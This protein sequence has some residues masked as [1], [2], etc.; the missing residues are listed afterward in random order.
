MPNF[1]LKTPIEDA[2]SGVGK[3]FLSQL[4]RLGIKTVKDL[5]WHLPTRYEDRSEIL[6]IT[7]IQGGEEA[8][9]RGIVQKNTTKRIPYRHLAITEVSIIDEDGSPLTVTFFNQPYIENTLKE[10]KV[11]V[12]KRS[13]EKAELMNIEEFIKKFKVSS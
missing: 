12:K 11:E 10:G 2:L 5:L 4:K 6:K 3:R 1:S 8:T 13:E 9:I 7:D